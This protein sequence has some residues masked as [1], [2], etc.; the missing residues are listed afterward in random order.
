[1]RK[2]ITLS[3]ILFL[4]FMSLTGCNGLRIGGGNRVEVYSFSGGN[5]AITLNNG[6][7]ILTAGSQ[8]FIG[9]DITFL[10]GEPTDIKSY[11][12][13]FYFFQ[14]G[15]QTSIKFDAA[16]VE[17]S[18]ASLRISSDMGSSSSETL[19]S[20]KAWDSLK[21]SLH[22]SLRG[23]YMNGGTFAYDIN[24]NVKEVFSAE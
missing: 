11:S 21:N 10:G 17:G 18:A 5:G 12:T 24:L 14:D 8:K 6:V 15:V 22:F 7:I 4:L 20:A 13:K 23:T 2:A 19:Q 1:M 3:I 16:T 9:G